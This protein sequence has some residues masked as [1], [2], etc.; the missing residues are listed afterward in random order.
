MWDKKVVGGMVFHILLLLIGI[1]PLFY[2][3]VW[4]YQLT[5]MKAVVA[6][7]L[8]FS[9]IIFFYTIFGFRELYISHSTFRQTSFSYVLGLVLA[10]VFGWIGRHFT[11]SLFTIPKQ[12]L[13]SQ[14]SSQL[15]RFWEKIVNVDAASYSEEML[16]LF[17]LPALLAIIFT[18]IGKQAEKSK[19]PIFKN[20]R[21]FKSPFFFIP[22]VVLVV[23]PT[24]A[25]FHVGNL[26]LITFII[27]AIIFRSLL[28]VLVYGEKFSH[29]KFIPFISL[30]PA[31]GI[32]YHRGNNIMA[33]GGVIDYIRVLLQTPTN[34]MEH[35]FGLVILSFTIIA[36][37]AS[38]SYLLSFKNMEKRE[39]WR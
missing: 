22:M 11:F 1:I 39:V 4:G 7:I 20:F 3:M 35:A 36:I 10:V 30:V 32:G 31:F 19:N 25:G 13:L 16:F 26:Q 24:F 23:A 34:F 38:I 29:D 21:F 15:P 2:L 9:F 27:S 28:L 12:Y 17:A 33:T 6:S 5:N 8:F 14:I 18:F 37:L